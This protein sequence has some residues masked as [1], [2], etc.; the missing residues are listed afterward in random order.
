VAERELA[1]SI[2]ALALT[3]GLGGG[4][5]ALAITQMRGMDMGVATR[6]GAFPSFV[7]DW[8]VM[9]T[10]MMLP[11]AAPAVRRYALTHRRMSAMVAFVTAYLAVW[12]VVGIAA[13]SVY[14]P[15]GTVVAGVATVLAGG[16]ELTSLK[17]HAR[18]HCR[19]RV[20][21]GY[22]LGIFCIGS[23]GGLMLMM[24]AVGAMSLSWMAAITAWV[25]LQKVFPPRRAIDVPI[26]MAIVAFGA[27]ILLAPSTIPGLV[28]SM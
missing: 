6:L 16:Y 27:V 7:G 13:F 25:L 1:P 17:R 26:A 24:L 4:C 23:S 22:R 11:G 20:H 14:R 2:R 8:A 10:A 3:L 12:I 15:H 19:E 21:S 18:Q 5:W 9:M 28:P